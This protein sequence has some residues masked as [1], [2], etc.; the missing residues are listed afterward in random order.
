MDTIPPTAYTRLTGQCVLSA[1][2]AFAKK[3]LQLPVGWKV[4][5]TITGWVSTTGQEELFALVLRYTM[6]PPDTRCI[7]AFRGSVTTG[8]WLNDFL[9]I[10]PTNFLPYPGGVTLLQTPQVGDGFQDIYVEVGHNVS[11]LSMQQQLFHALSA[12]PI[13]QLI[14]T[15]HSLGSALAELFMFDYSLQKGNGRYP[16]ITTAWLIDYAAPCVG[17]STWQQ[18][19]ATYCNPLFSSTWAQ[20]IRIVNQCDIVP[21]LPPTLEQM[22]SAF[23]IKFRLDDWYWELKP[24]LQHSMLNYAFVVNQA[25]TQPSHVWTGT[26]PDLSG[27]HATMLSEAPDAVTAGALRLRLQAMQARQ[28]P[29]PPQSG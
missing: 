11:G 4:A 9:S 7:V 14:V 17:D 10:L 24:G 19:Y 6:D 20:S 29:H 8:D 18:Q 27:S 22:A 12:R 1:Y 13:S 26:F 25:L 21:S 23:D 3:P 2:N 16:G 5:Q 28:A 15:G